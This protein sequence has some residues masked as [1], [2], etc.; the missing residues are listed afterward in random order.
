M[1]PKKSDHYESGKETLFLKI[2]KSSLYTVVLWL[3]ICGSAVIFMGIEGNHQQLVAW[4]NLEELEVFNKTL[5]KVRG[6]SSFLGI[7]EKLCVSRKF[8]RHVLEAF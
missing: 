8:E 3:F 7:L 2:M 1:I 5:Y 4:R 6:K